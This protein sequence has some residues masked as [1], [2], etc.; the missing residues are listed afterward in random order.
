MMEKRV[1]SAERYKRYSCRSGR[2]RRGEAAPIPLVL[3]FFLC[4]LFVSGC[5]FP[6]RSTVSEGGPRTSGTRAAASIAASAEYQK[7][8]TLFAHGDHRG[9]ASL[10]KTLAQK[11]DLTSE[12][13]SFL[14]AQIRLCQEGQTGKTA[15]Q[16]KSTASSVSLA[17]LSP[18]P[19][20]AVSLSASVSNCGP[21]ALLFA[22]KQMG[23]SDATLSLPEIT[24]VA[25]T[26]GERGTNLEGMV[27]A[28]RSLGLSAEAVQVDG[29][30]MKRLPTPFIAWMDG[31]HYVTTL[32]VG[33]DALTGA[34]T[35]I[36]HDPNDGD[37][38][39]TN[40][41]LPLSRFLS[42][43][44]GIVLKLAKSTPPAIPTGSR[45]VGAVRADK[46]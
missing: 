27:R 28:A 6:P 4:V 31:N 16:T 44:G 36:Y 14:A 8:R 10:L 33:A 41:S 13:A 43:S 37:N 22:A 25:E 30:A 17:S 40:K 45:A 7:A 39:D 3:S 38:G 11:P 18:I 2:F 32:T 12:D 20:R 35:V 21:R 46:H 23:V 9:A 5:S 42:R 26:K 19:T 29:D 1:L 15:Q 24:R 34:E